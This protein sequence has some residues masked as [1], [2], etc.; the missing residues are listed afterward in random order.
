M[1]KNIQTA[2]VAPRLVVYKNQSETHPTGWAHSWV[3]HSIQPRALCVQPS[4][5]SRPDPFQQ[6]R[7]YIKHNESISL[8]ARSMMDSNFNKP[9][10]VYCRHHHSVIGLSSSP[11]A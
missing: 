6:S 2:S 9:A 7:V 3:P 5:Q 1:N 8:V 10:L 4:Q 11:M